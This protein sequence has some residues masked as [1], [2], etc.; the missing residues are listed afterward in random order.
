MLIRKIQFL[1][2]FQERYTINKKYLKCNKNEKKHDVSK[3]IVTTTKSCNRDENKRTVVISL[4]H[5]VPY[6]AL[7]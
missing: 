4:S 2:Y 1:L 5:I 3:H 7:V 6:L